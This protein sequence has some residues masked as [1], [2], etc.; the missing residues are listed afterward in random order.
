MKVLQINTVYKTGG[1][2]GR[3][4]YDLKNIMERSGI[5]SYVAFGYGYT[6]DASEQATLFRIDTDKDL[7]I[8][9]VQT[10]LIGHHGFNNIHETRRLLKWIDKVNPDIIHLHNIHNHYVNIKLLLTYIEKRHIP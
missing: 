5:E 10:K 7:F 6:P 8:S 3:I 4:V 1:S 9:K 2:T